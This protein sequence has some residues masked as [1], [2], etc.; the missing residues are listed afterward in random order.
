MCRYFDFDVI[1][2]SGSSSTDSDS[3]Q[4]TNASSSPD[5]GSNWAPPVPVKKDQYKERVYVLLSFFSR[6][7]D[8]EVRFK[9]FVA[10]GKLF[11][12][13]KTF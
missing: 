6:N 5:K 7:R 1:M 2:A 12:V 10:L 8:E 13:V 9:S 4:Q 11:Y 3:E